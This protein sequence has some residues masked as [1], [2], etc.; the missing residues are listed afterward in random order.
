MVQYQ[1]LDLNDNLVEEE[2]CD[3]KEKPR[4]LFASCNEERCPA[5]CV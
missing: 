2:L 4:E 3:Q 1:C 5:R